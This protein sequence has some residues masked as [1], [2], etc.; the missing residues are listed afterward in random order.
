MKFDFTECRSILHRALIDGLAANSSRIRALQAKEEIWAIAY[1][2]IPWDPYIGVA[3]CLKNEIDR[4]GLHSGGWK[5]SHFIE[6][7]STKA[8]DSAVEYT[9]QAYESVSEDPKRCQDVAR[10]IYLAAADALL[11]EGVAVLLQSLGVNAPVI[12]DKLPWNYF[13][14]VVTDADGVIKANYC[15]IICA[16][17]ATRRLLGMVV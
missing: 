4:S 10:L 7:I 17:R 6:N 13:K 9:F 12:R 3:V 14:Y 16:N 15:D 1:D 2:I 8:F 11:D 5:N